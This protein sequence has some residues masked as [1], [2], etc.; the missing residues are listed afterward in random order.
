MRHDLRSAIPSSS[1]VLFFFS[2]FFFRF[3]DALL[4]CYE[5]PARNQT[6][7][8][9]GLALALALAAGGEDFFDV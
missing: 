2:F 6:G 4:R 8:F 3:C 9:G 5:V 7:C 1:L